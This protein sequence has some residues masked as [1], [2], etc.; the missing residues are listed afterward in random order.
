MG[1]EIPIPFFIDNCVAD[2]VGRIL[3]DAGHDVAFLRECMP[4][5][6]KD[7]VVAVACAENARVL[8]THDKD[9]KEIA[10]ELNVTQKKY[11]RLIEFPC[12]ARSQRRH[13]E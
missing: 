2:S 12:V 10:K 3:I 5:D 6:T 1:K 7:P 13:R 8:V 11:K 9:F 4:T